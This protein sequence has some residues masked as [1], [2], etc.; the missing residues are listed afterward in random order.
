[1]TTAFECKE[2]G[3]QYFREEKYASAIESYAAAIV[4]DPSNPIPFQ[5][6]ALAHIRLNQYDLALQDCER[7]LELSPSNMK[8][9]YMKGQALL[10]LDR[11]DPA[12]VVLRKALTLA[13][14]QGSPSAGEISNRILQAYKLS[15]EK[16]ERQRIRQENKTLDTLCKMINESKLVSIRNIDRSQMENADDYNFAVEQIK[17][18]SNSLIATLENALGNQD[19]QQG[20]RE[21]PDYLLDKINFN[22]FVDPVVVPSGHSYERNVISEYLKVSPFDPL[23][24]ERLT[25]SQ[26]RPNIQ[27]RDAAEDFMEKNGWAVDY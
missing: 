24:R 20:K 2:R 12:K 4:K 17:H 11:P 14:S 9:W 1:M 21:I 5:N 8:G 22:I 23:T 16:R 18:E 13:I 25:I 3:N 7:V 10:G 19:P 26:L 27:L 15:W 6:R